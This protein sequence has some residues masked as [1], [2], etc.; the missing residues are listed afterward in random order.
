[1][2][3]KNKTLV[4]GDVM[5]DHYLYCTC[6][7]ISPEAPVPIANLNKEELI[8]GGA[9]NVANNLINLGVDV[10]LCGII[11]KDSYGLELINEL[12]KN[13]IENLLYQ[14]VNRKTTIKSR[15][16]S[17][18]QQQ[19]RID[20]EDKFSISETEENQIIEKLKS[21]IT[22][23]NCIVISDY[24]KGLL[25][26]GLL[27]KIFFEAK[28]LNIR[29]FVDPKIPPFNKYNGADIIK[30]NKKEAYLETGIEL[31]DEVSI[32]NAC[33]KLFEQTGINKIVITLSEDGVAVFENHKL[34]FIPTK[35]K[36]IFD[37][38]GA[39]DT[40]LAALS[41]KYMEHKNLFQASEYANYAAAC[42]VS[43]VGSATT[44]LKE[45]DKI[46]KQENNE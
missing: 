44:S 39:G 27:R 9:A 1:M 29:V 34:R 25:T 35:A 31:V 19:L 6:E 16:I 15:V 28:G 2:I 7:R 18:G 12:K 38:T 14:C 32:K 40:F 21:K 30:P 13:N 36:K 5:L 37:V 4:I 22:Q 8:L 20:R 26:D 3:S 17:N 41:F 45:I 11:G 24:N 42:V 33:I 43:K 23:C 46:I 10:I